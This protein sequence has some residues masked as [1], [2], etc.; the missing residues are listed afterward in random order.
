MYLEYGTI[1]NSKLLICFQQ[2]WQPIAMQ[3]VEHATFLTSYQGITY[4]FISW[5]ILKTWLEFP[6]KAVQV[7]LV[8]ASLLPL[9][10]IIVAT[11]FNPPTDP[12]RIFCLD[13]TTVTSSTHRT[14]FRC[15]TM[16]LIW[17]RFTS[18][19]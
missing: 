18:S 13:R 11:C 7:H 2:A 16:P 19:D 17:L 3:T 1:H 4:E 9:G 14:I 8:M 6:L 10:D 15:T 12:Q 5:A